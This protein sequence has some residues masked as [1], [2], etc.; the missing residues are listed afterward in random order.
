VLGDGEPAFEV[1]SEA[2]G[3]RL[4]VG[5]DVG[6]GVAA[7]RAEQRD[8]L[9][10]APAVD[11][12]LVG[13]AEQD[14]T[15]D[16]IPDRAF[17]EAEA[18]GQL[19]DPGVFRKD[20][21]ERRIEP[22]HLASGRQRLGPVE[23]E[24]RRADPDVVGGRVRE[25]AVDAEHGEL[26]LLPGL[27]AVRE[28]HAIGGAVPLDHRAAAL[29]ERIVQI[30]VEPDLGVIVDH[31]LEHEGRAGRI[32]RAD[33]L[34]DGDVDPIPVEGDSPGRA[35]PLERGRIEHLPARIVEVCGAGLGRMSW[36][37]IGGPLGFRSAP[38]A[39]KST[40]TRRASL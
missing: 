15:R 29:A 32:E 10:P 6:P 21:I 4:P 36:V 34:G 14:R 25:R 22:H 35:P 17:A 11:R 38:A 2:V 9:I 26:E 30:A 18:F 7:V 20:A 19:L 40:S 5:A 1:P 24:R 16:R 27:Y 33:A 37:L 12:V 8:A 31:D 3:A 23:A 39:L 28:D 13:V